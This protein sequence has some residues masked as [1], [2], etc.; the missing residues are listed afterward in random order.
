MKTLMKHFTTSNYSDYQGL[1]HL[2]SDNCA[3]NC[4]CN[5]DECNDLATYPRFK[6]YQQLSVPIDE[7]SREMCK[8]TTSRIYQ[9]L[10]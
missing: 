4:K 9:L 5:M 6:I 3:A 2:W 10:W 7:H 1:L 8:T